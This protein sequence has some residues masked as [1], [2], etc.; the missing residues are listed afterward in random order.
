MSKAEMED[1]KKRS[2]IYVAESEDEYS[3]QPGWY[4]LRRIRASLLFADVEQDLK[5][6]V[7]GLRRPK[8]YRIRAYRPTTEVHPQK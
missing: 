8:S 2:D 5:A 7:A 6:Y 4:P 3:C 1:L